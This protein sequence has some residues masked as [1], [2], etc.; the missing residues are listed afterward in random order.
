M[1]PCVNTDTGATNPKVINA[2]RLPSH[3]VCLHWR[4]TRSLRN[5][6]HM[7]EEPTS[8][9]QNPQEQRAKESNTTPTASQDKTLK[10]YLLLQRY[11][12]TRMT[13]QKRKE[14]DELVTHGHW[15]KAIRLA[16]FLRNACYLCRFF[17]SLLNT[18]H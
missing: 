12:S 11:R 4:V 17:F 2:T 8:N 15:L 6:G 10:S 13:G 1:S 14:T 18:G 5:L 16:C 9:T 3:S 7:L